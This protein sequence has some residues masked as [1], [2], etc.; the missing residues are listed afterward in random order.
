M[1]TYRAFISLQWVVERIPRRL[2]YALVI[3][4]SKLALLLARN[5][6]RRLESNL[7]T[8]LPE[9]DPKQIGR[10]AR[11]NFRNHAKAYIDLMQLPRANAEAMRSQLTYTGV[12]YLER[13][14][15]LGRGVMV[16]SAHMGSWEI[17]AAIWASTV[18]PVNLFAEE[19]EPRPLYEWYR[20]TR[21]R[22]GISVLPLNRHGLRQVREALAANEMVVT[23]IDRDILGT[24]VMLDFFG[25][26]APIP[27][28][29]AALALRGG[30]PIL[31][32]CV[33]R[34]PDDTYHAVAY[35][36]V[37]AAPSGDREA[38][39]RRTT[40]QLVRCLEDMI[41]KH[42]EQWHVPHMIWPEP[43][44]KLPA[45]TPGAMAHDE[46]AGI[47]AADAAKPTGRSK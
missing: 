42:P 12:E 5:A 23:A 30:T 4:L 6:R 40:E 16:V 27:T 14:R 31:P 18:A 24:G 1:W 22:L 28:G 8:A 25:R 13:A 36:P 47:P 46:Q 20:N 41:R 37:F 21:A 3:P 33:T 10:L 35:P 7:A 29:P 45:V 19:L 39:V 43:P 9:C 26:P 2:A 44:A 38:D 15:E 34:N 17:V 32:V 11:L